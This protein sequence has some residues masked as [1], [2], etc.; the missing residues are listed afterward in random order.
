MNPY[1]KPTSKQPLPEHANKV[2]DGIVFDVYQ[3][4][5][6]Q[7]DGSVKTFEKLKRDD[8][9]LVI[10]IS[11]AGEFIFSQEEQPGKEAFL[12][13]LGGRVE[14]GEEPIIA[15]QR[16]L[17]EE[18]GYTSQEWVLIEASQPISKVEWAVYT[19]VARGC[20]KTDEQKL[21]SGEKIELK[22][23]S[24]DEA[25]ELMSQDNFADKEGYLPRLAI[26]ALYNP[27]KRQELKNIL[28]GSDDLN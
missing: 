16:E 5:Q 17:L 26:H 23:V 28:L 27:E 1:I 7:F 9:V 3:W 6:P 24:F 15:A 11:E 25:V 14:K 12:G 20:K 18:A 22:L 4:E 19:Y 13:F 10:P 8:T 21:D 2:F